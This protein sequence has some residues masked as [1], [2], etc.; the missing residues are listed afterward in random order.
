[1][2]CFAENFLTRQI[3]EP[4][5]LD[6]ASPSSSGLDSDNAIGAVE[7]AIHCKHISHAPGGLA[8]DNDPAMPAQ[9]AT[10]PDDNVF[11]GDADTQPVSISSRFDGNAVISRIEF[12][13]INQHIL[14]G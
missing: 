14:A 9:A 6:N 5:I 4:H 8:P 12:T 10:V 13:I 11:G 2:N 7:L 1:V 3:L